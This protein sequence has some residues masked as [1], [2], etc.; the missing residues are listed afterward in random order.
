MKITGGQIT[1]GRKVNLGD[2]NS[3]KAEATIGF[4]LDDGEDIETGASVAA[5]FATNK[6]N[7][8]LGF[9]PVTPAAPTGVKEAVAAKLNA[10]DEDKK[11]RAGKKAP[12][13]T[14][15][16]SPPPPATDAAAIVDDETPAISTG[17]ERVDPNNPADAASV[18][19][20]DWGTAEAVTPISDKDLTDACAKK[21]STLQDA[22][23]IRT[24]IGKFVSPPKTLVDIPQ[25]SR[26][27]FLN[28]LAKLEK[29]K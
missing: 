14:P 16:A 6:V 27:K 25:E 22:P 17:D 8:L 18:V 1:Y 2:Y 26:Q 7:E 10:T 29:A 11:T 23:L 12:P 28:D 20:E 4:L 19:D 13:K 9:K 5:L 15:P 3:K 24:L 21:N